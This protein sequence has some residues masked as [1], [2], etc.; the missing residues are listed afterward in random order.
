M[1]FKELIDLI[2][3]ENI[4]GLENAKSN[5]V[6]FNILDKY[7][8]NNIL[9][10][11]AGYGFDNLYKPEELIVFLLSTGIDINHKKNKRGSEYSALHMAVANNHYSIVKSLLENGAD[12]EIQEGNGNTPL[13][14]AVANYRGKKESLEIVNLLISNKASLDTKNFHNKSPR[15][16][17]SMIGPGI[18]AGYN[19]K[20][21]DLR[22][23]L[24]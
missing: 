1:A 4:K 16:I 11:Y 24:E 10:A 21:W 12:I 23:I 15:D 20:D 2:Y 17:I 9:I 14:I 5:G 6:D 7:D 8:G 19:S 13:F 22:F 3:R 18:D